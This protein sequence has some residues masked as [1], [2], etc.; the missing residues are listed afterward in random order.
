M[1]LDDEGHLSKRS[2][3]PCAKCVPYLKDPPETCALPRGD[4]ANAVIVGC[5]CTIRALP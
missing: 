3:L 4:V 2:K 5:V 1:I